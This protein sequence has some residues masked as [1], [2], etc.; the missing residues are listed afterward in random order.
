MTAVIKSGT[1][2]DGAAVRPLR[3]AAVP[4]TIVADERD[5]LR[6]EITRL[7]EALA[8]ARRTAAEREGDV[9]KALERGRQEGRRAG[10][11]EAEDRQKERLAVLERGIGQARDDLRDGLA[12]LE[13][14]AALLARE[15]LSVMLGDAAGSGDLVHRL[16]RHQVARI[17]R[18]TIL[19]IEVSPADFPA[20]AALDSLCAALDLAPGAIV[21]RRDLASGGCMMTFTLGRL[22]IG[23]GQQWGKLAATLT[24]IA[25]GSAAR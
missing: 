23:I 10:F 1:A 9:A 18:S 2:V 12:S 21:A 6:A 22:D 15:C 7:H 3:P 17:D 5:G 13:G 4:R 14:T 8:Q 24:E 11:A 20:P 16:I 19:R 25:G